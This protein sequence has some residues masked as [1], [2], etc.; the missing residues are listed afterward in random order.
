MQAATAAAPACA[1]HNM[2]ICRL[3]NRSSLRLQ[4]AIEELI[5][6][7]EGLKRVCNVIGIKLPPKRPQESVNLLQ[8]MCIE[9]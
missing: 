2:V 1:H 6:G 3:C 7:V 9:C 5:E 8:Q 4:L